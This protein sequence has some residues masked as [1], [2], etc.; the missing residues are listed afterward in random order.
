MKKVAVVLSG[1]GKMDGSEID[2]TVLTLLALD[3]AGVAYQCIAPNIPQKTVIN[4]ITGKEEPNTT[5]N[6]L[7]ESARI[8]RGSIID[9]KHANPADYAAV[10]FP[11]GFGAAANL[12]NFS[13]KG[14]DCELQPDVLAFAQA[15]A[16]AGKPSGYICIAP[17]MISKIYGPGVQLTIGNDVGTANAINKMG[18]THVACSAQEFVVDK[19]HKVVS[20]PAYMLAKSIGDAATGIEGLVKEVVALMG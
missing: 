17:T 2:E 10:I 6:V 13:D 14:A 7:V 8:A 20:T 9:I 19:K 3:R 4:H 12:S 5:R 16:K 11:G 18:G 15:M 1:C